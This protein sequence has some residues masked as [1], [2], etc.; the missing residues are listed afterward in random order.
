MKI[1]ISSVGKSDPMTLMKSQ[2]TDEQKVYEGS[3]LQICRY[4]DFDVVVLYMS[5]QI[6]DLDRQDQRYEKALNALK[7]E[8]HKSFV[9][10]K[11]ED[12]KMDDV[13][14]FDTF[15]DKFEA[16]IKDCVEKYG[17][18]SEFY[19]N[20]S[21][22]T[23]AMKST[24]QIIASLTK[25]KARTIQVKDPSKGKGF[26]YGDIKDYDHDLYWEYNEDRH[27]GISRC[28]EPEDNNFRLKI[29][30]E[31]LV[32][33]I[34]NYEYE[35]ALDL[36]KSLTPKLDEDTLNYITFAYERYMMRSNEYIRYQKRCHQKFIPYM[37]DTKRGLFEY[38]LWLKIKIEKG[39]LSDFCRGITPFM[40][41]A[42]KYALKEK[43]GI[44]MDKYLEK[45]KKVDCLTAH[46]LKKDSQGCEILD[47]LDDN[48]D[49]YKDQFL[50]EAQMIPVLQEKCDDQNLN[51]AFQDLNYFKFSIRNLTS[52]NIVS[53]SKED[54]EKKMSYGID[55][56]VNDVKK[57]LATL[58]FDT[59]NEWN[60]YEKM[61]EVI[62]NK[63]K[64]V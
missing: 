53:V 61:N 55:H 17:E 44:N 43:C 51:D 19:F 29:Q 6:V 1:L 20:I 39:D 63:I 18:N 59:R 58:G 27:N 60:S 35:A 46:M 14:V 33:M 64:E 26:R 47:I 62:I 2:E 40:Y 28:S 41:A 11:K 32:S 48:F 22:G 37:E 57:I 34:E 4:Y 24:F 49:G 25:Y 36:A 38:S 52:H 9:L 13:Q 30:K 8:T 3:I 15:Y 50:S 5:K 56:Y 31:I 16:I 23:P 54:I 12:V 21:S 7:A 42:S 10:R 45:V